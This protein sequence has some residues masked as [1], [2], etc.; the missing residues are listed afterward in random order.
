L[1]N[2]YDIRLKLDDGLRRMRDDVQRYK[3]QLRELLR[4]RYGLEPPGGIHSLR[5]TIYRP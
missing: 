2:D 5:P 4:V 1:F 3:E